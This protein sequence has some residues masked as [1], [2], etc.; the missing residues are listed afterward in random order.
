M[1]FY[2]RLDVRILERKVTVRHL[3]VDETKIPA[4]AKGLCTDYPASDESKSLGKPRK[5]LALYDG[6]G[7]CYIFRVPEGVLCIKVRVL[8]RKIPDVLK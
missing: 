6:I 7:N 1:T 8:Y 4:V 3:T 2:V 5:V